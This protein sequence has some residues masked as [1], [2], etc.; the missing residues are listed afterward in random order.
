MNKFW[1]RSICLSL[2]FNFEK[3]NYHLAFLSLFF[4]ALQIG[5]HDQ[6]KRNR[7]QYWHL[8]KNQEQ[9]KDTSFTSK[10]FLWRLDIIRVLISVIPF[11]QL[12]FDKRFFS[13][14][15]EY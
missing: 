3:K 4:F 11:L 9:I 7:G 14:F 13:Y 8:I 15:S 10:L 2:L 1:N 12:N 5:T 6:L